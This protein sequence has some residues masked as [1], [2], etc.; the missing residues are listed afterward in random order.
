M[1]DCKMNY[2]RERLIICF[3]LDG[4]ICTEQKKMK[5]PERYYKAELKQHMKSLV[6]EL[7]DKGHII[8]IDT[9]RSSGVSKWNVFRRLKTYIQTRNQLSNW[10]I[11]YH[12]LRV[13]A[14][15]PADLY[16]DDRALPAYMFNKTK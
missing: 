14:K 13:G 3:D 10:G 5:I 11:K 16:V 6:N 9:A 7:Y 2:V 1:K 15:L 12:K 4:T 8:L